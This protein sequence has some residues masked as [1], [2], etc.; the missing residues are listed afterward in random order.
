MS[1]SRG[2][3]EGLKSAQSSFGHRDCRFFVIRFSASFL[4]WRFTVRYQKRD[5]FVKIFTF[6]LQ[7]KGNRE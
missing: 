6:V 3:P 7:D 4:P 1:V 2:N 5:I